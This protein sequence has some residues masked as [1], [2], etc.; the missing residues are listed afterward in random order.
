MTRLE[1]RCCCHP[2]K[3][4]GYLR[5]HDRDVHPGDLVFDVRLTPLVFGAPKAMQ[6]GAGVSRVVLTIGHVTK[7]DRVWLAVKSN[8]TPIELL[9][10]VPTFE[11]LP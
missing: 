4:L 10:K 6:L 5:L 7:G 3:L 9:R 1:V 11:A 2:R 8:D